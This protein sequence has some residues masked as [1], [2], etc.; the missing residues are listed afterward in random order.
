M[1]C[2]PGPSRRSRPG[3][4][5][6]VLAT[7]PVWLTL[8]DWGAG[9]ARPRRQ[10]ALGLA[11][12]ARGLGFLV[13]PAPARG[14]GRGLLVLVLGAFAWAAGSILS[15]RAVAAREPHAGERHAAPG[16]RRRRSSPT[17]S[18]WARPRAS[19][20]ASSRRARCCG[21]AYMVGISSLVGF[22]A[23]MW[24]LRVASPTL[25][26]TYAFVNPVVALVVGARSAG[27]TLSSRVARRLAR[28]RL[29]RGARRHG[30][31]R[32]TEGGGR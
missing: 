9:G 26:G 17:A 6:L 29:R 13:G 4:A 2:S 5:A 10:G 25:V 14:A 30:R 20:P 15:R 18:C 24:L 11:L 28:D 27:E 8:L 12:G 22:T 3:V 32:S 16:G 1:G 23:Y 21:F 7:I 19:T 31:A